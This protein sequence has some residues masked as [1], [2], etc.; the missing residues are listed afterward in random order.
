[1][2]KRQRFIC[3]IGI[4]IL[5]LGLGVPSPGKASIDLTAEEKAWI[6]Q[7]PVIRVSSEP[8]YAPFD[9][10]EEGRP[11]GFSV[12]YLNLVAERA[13][14]HL[15]Y[16]QDTWKNLVEKGKRKEIDLLHTIFFTPERAPF[17]HYTEPYK[18]VVNGIFVRNGVEGVA[19]LQDLA[20]RRVVIAKGDSLAEHLPQLVPDAEFVF[21]DTYEEIL[22]SVSLGQGDA[23]VMDIAVVH[24]LIRKLTLTNIRPA[25]EARVDIADHYMSYRLAVRKD[26]PELQSIL[27]KAMDTITPDEMAALE[28][29]WFAL[30]A[31]AADGIALTPEERQWLRDN[32]VIRVHNE[33]D[34]PPFNY[35]EFGRPRGLSIDYMDRLAVKLGLD[36]EYVSGPSW[37]E[38]LDRVKRKE[39]D[40]MLNIV[41]TEDRQKY[42]LYTDPYVK[43]PNVIVSSANNAYADIEELFGKVVAFPKGFFYEEVLTK[44]FP[45]IERLPV[46]DTLASLKAVAY[47][48][49]DAAIGEAAVIQTL[50]NRNMLVGL[51]ISG[52]VELGNPDLANLRIGVRNDWPLLQSALMKAMATITPQEMDQIRQKW[53]VG[54]KQPPDGKAAPPAEKQAG[55]SRLSL[56]PEERA[57]LAEH[58]M[59][60]FTGDPDWL[61]Q[62]AFTSEGQY[63]GIVAA[64]LDLIET[65]L[66]V[67]FDRVPVASWE[68][69]VRLVETGE[70]EML[71]ESTSSQRDTM[72]FTEPYL[73]FPVVLIAR[74]GTQSIAEPG[75]LEGQRL[76]VVKDY[77]YVIPFR[78]QYPDLDYVEVASVREG[79]L[80][81]SAGQVDAFLSAAS[82]ASYLIS[83][84]GLTNLKV[85]STTEFSIDLGFGVN[86]NASELAGILDKALADITQAEKLV[87]RRT[88]IPVIDAPASQ[89]RTPISYGRLIAY[90]TAVFLMLCLLTWL[91]VKTIKREQIAVHFGSTWF[92]GLVLATLSVFV[93]VVAFVGWYM[94]ERGRTRYLLSTDENLRGI[95]SVSEDRLDLWLKERVSY[96]GRLGRDP[97]LA[98]IT[99]RL[100]QVPPNK[101]ALLA[102]AALR[103]ARFFF[104]HA[105]DIFTNI[106]FFIIDPAYISIGSM[107]DANLGTLNLIAE[108][109]PELL[110]RAFEGQVGFVPPIRSDVAL[111]RSTTRD[112]DRKPP[113]MF[114]IGPV[115]DTDGRIL[116]VMTLRVDP[117]EDF[118]RALKS[119]GGGASRETYAFDRHGV[120]LSE[121][122]F[123]DQLRRIGLLT[124]DQTSALSIE[125]RDPGGNMLDGFQPTTARSQQPLTRMASRALA[126][127]QEM[128]TAGLFSGNSSTE[129][130]MDG[131]RDYRGVT[132][133][134]AWLWN[135]DL[136]VGLVVEVDM[137][138]ALSHYYRSRTTITGILGFTLLLSV[139]AILFVLIIGERASRAL[140]AARDN[141]EDTVAARTAELREKQ[142]LLVEAEERA[143]LL[144]DSAGEGL[145]GVDA[146][147]KLRFINP[148]G[149]RL[150]GYEPQELIGEGI[151]TK[152]HYAH[153]DGT[154][155]PREECPMYRSFTEGS[156]SRI[157]DE[158]LWRKDGTP[159]PVEY[160]SMPV[161]KDGKVVG[162][163]VTF[164][165]I[166]ERKRMEAKLAAEQERLQGILDTSPV[167]VGISVEGVIQ[168]ANAHLVDFFGTRQGDHTTSIYVNPED[169]D[170]IVK[171]LE[172][173]GT[174]RNY[175]LRVYNAQGEVC[176]VLSNY[177]AIEYEG[178]PAIL[179]WWT[180]ITD[181]KATS[182]ELKSKFDELARFRQMAIGRELKM[183]ELKKEINEFFKANGAEEKYKIH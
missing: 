81:V 110:Q 112:S 36:V 150:L 119:Y 127:R 66:G 106:G 26:W 37:N 27:Q 125:I 69:A 140:L 153:A 122:R 30:P 120:M 21:M 155:Y 24:Y 177:N 138:E 111:G 178:Q 54:T 22:K 31:F 132:V 45:Q 136:D 117:W 134:G 62:E 128:K 82:T 93:L 48:R 163:V 147:G 166:S 11:S 7:H 20:G 41:K 151:H 160:T 129:S 176:D 10:V 32:P 159:F 121:S 103:E 115:Q 139:G 143:R 55:Q 167:S 4:A 39:L 43:N 68:E 85:I 174:V 99:K 89:T 113:T 50:I 1:M 158:V 157:T 72:I 74:Q 123:E 91:L 100:L 92:R 137:A 5:L 19:S 15:E 149:C 130:D 34:W 148:A 180:D 96:L 40:V 173:T 78:R 8:D 164:M 73:T 13:G 95:L 2:R 71:S 33:I 70:V 83:E 104:K 116:A 145:F 131:Y 6:E 25:G 133:L 18:T 63:I 87:I 60:R 12:D 105:E 169:R 51:R 142:K 38:F 165:D 183:I 65:R 49:A 156:S 97:Q 88:W 114:F 64:I 35:F 90:S 14:L 170:I 52:E 79:L 42:L 107:R 75:N 44:S 141:L 76:A 9:F 109:H 175:E 57:W 172:Q 181:I 168:Y 124:E 46:E 152:A 53:L 67:R 61:P 59:I 77:G 118:A 135:A 16:V 171:E 144:L 28:A 126:L 56:S 98:A 23:T 47:G 29:R 3:S 94:L 146:E 179:S 101:R 102:S 17:F 161:Q 58:P 86:K 162:A 108:Q 84:L 154:P 80:Q 182:E